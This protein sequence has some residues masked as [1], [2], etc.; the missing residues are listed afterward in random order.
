MLGQPRTMCWMQNCV[1]QPARELA[2][3]EL[4]QVLKNQ[5]TCTVFPFVLETLAFSCFGQTRGRHPKNER[6]YKHQMCFCFSATG[7]PSPRGISCPPPPRSHDS[8]VGAM[9][10]SPLDRDRGLCVIGPVAV[11]PVKANKNIEIGH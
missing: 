9:Q 8:A 2:R 11:A 6:I 1:S 5:R 4:T 3:E 10:G 7:E